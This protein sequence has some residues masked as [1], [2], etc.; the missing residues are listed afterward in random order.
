[1]E[2]PDTI[3]LIDMGDEVTWCDSPD[4][5]GGVHPDDVCEYVKSAQLAEANGI[6]KSC[7]GCLDEYGTLNP[8]HRI[9]I[10]DHINKHNL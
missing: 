1:M 3:Y 8:L 2:T 9:F 5:S 6:I 4:P 10:S 7:Q